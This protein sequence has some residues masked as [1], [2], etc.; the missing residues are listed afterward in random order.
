LINTSSMFEFH[1]LVATIV[2]LN[3]LEL[4]VK[5]MPNY[6]TEKSYVHAVLV[7]CLKLPWTRPEDMY[8]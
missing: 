3:I 1:M 6:P 2:M 7:L 8:C 4:I 5:I